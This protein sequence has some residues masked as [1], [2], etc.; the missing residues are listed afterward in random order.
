MQY[1]IYNDVIKQIK[2]AKYLGV[3]T[4]HR[5]SWNEHINY[6]TSKANNVNA[7]FSRTSVNA[8]LISEAIVIGA[9]YVLSWNTI[10]LCGLLIHRRIY[11]QLRQCKDVQL[12]Q[13]RRNQSGC[14]GFGR[15]SFFS[16]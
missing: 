7:F 10:A 4:D 2:H 5:L 8:P 14:S 3:I 13:G 12:G 1:Y 9:W 16:R 6:I 11:Q 15:T